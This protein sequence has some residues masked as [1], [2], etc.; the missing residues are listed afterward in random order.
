MEGRGSFL[1]DLSGYVGRA[2]GTGRGLFHDPRRFVAQACGADGDS[3]DGDRIQR[4]IDHGQMDAA[5]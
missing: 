1:G 3:P 5:S 2:G 4:R